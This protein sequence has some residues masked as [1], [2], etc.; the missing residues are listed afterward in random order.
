MFSKRSEKK[1][2]TMKPPVGKI[3]MMTGRKQ[4]ITLHCVEMKMKLGTAEGG[5]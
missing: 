5:E 4:Y 1:H 2:E 3:V